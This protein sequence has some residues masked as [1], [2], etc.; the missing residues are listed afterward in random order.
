M[1]KKLISKVSAST[2]FLIAAIILCAAMVLVFAKVLTN[3]LIV[4]VIIAGVVAIA[5]FILHIKGIFEAKKKQK[6]IDD[7]YNMLKDRTLSDIATISNLNY[8][9]AK[10]A[11]VLHFI[12]FNDLFLIAKRIENK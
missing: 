1:F 10:A 6:L 12:A 8:E 11:D 4:S 2:I 3:L 7:A 9:E 5:C